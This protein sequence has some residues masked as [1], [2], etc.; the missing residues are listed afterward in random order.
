MASNND[1]PGQMNPADAIA[2]KI[3]KPME[4]NLV[5]SIKRVGSGGSGEIY[6][7]SL[8]RFVTD[9]ELEGSQWKTRS[10]VRKVIP[11]SM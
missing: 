7:M 1:E 3:L 4:V 8:K 10:H 9:Q 2:Q 6:K 11:P 5:S